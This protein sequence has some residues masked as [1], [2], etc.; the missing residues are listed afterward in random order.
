PDRCGAAARGLPLAPN[1]PAA[2]PPAD[3]RVGNGL[4]PPIAAGA[5]P[6]PRL[7]PPGRMERGEDRQR[8]GAVRPGDAA[9]TA[10]PSPRGRRGPTGRAGRWT[11]LVAD[12]GAD[13]VGRVRPMVRAGARPRVRRAPAARHGQAHSRRRPL[14]MA[15][16]ARCDRPGRG[17]PG[18]RRPDPRR[19]APTLLAGVLAAAYVIISP[20]S[21]DLAAHLL[22]AKLFSTEGFGI[23]SNWWYGGH[24]LVMYSVLFPPVAAAPTPQLAAAVAAAG[25]AALFGPLARH[26]FGERAWLG[27]L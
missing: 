23:W 7:G 15:R 3:R 1:G 11:G 16:S 21:L 9:R 12:V 17:L 26:H 20:P 10:A 22:R 14:A 6:P 13:P 8:L 25:S 4:N 5:P 27:S 24:H 2:S 18:M 19:V